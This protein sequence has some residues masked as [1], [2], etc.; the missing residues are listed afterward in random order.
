MDVN[1]NLTIKVNDVQQW[2]IQVKGPWIFT[3]FILKENDF[4][5]K[6]KSISVMIKFFDN[7][8]VATIIPWW[9]WDK[10]KHFLMYQKNLNLLL[11]YGNFK[12]IA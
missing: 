4:I 7:L 11:I 10:L 12:N 1:I 5:I 6:C 2:A 9:F 3:L 8:K